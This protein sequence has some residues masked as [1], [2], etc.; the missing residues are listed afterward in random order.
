MYERIVVALDG[1]AAAEQIL[2]HAETLAERFGSTLVLLRATPPA[3]PGV[4]GEAVLMSGGSLDRAAIAAAP[5]QEAADY[6]AGLAHRLRQRGFV[7]DTVQPEGEPGHMIVQHLRRAGADLV[8]MTTHGRGGL[9]RA[10]FGSVA[11]AVLRQ[12]PCPM[13]LVRINPDG[14][15]G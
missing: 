13:L 15:L 8:A 14:H 2:P 9:S 5:R 1:S 3:E 7:I 11:D 4:V 10:A 6:L 12:A